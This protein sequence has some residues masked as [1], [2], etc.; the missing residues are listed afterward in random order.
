[1]NDFNF[2]CSKDVFEYLSKYPDMI[3]VIPDILQIAFEE[4]K[5]AKFKLEVYHDPE[6]ENEYLI[7]YVSFSNY[8][9]NIIEKIDA[10]EKKCVDLLIDKTGWL[11]IDADFKIN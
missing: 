2:Y 9:K 4:L 1:M 11:I 10:V 6:I 8:N 5:D 3:E 7:L